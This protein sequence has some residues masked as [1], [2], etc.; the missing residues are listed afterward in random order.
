[1]RTATTA[2]G[3]SIVLDVLGLSITVICPLENRK[4]WDR[5]I[6]MESERLIFLSYIFLSSCFLV[7][8]QISNASAAG[9]TIVS[10]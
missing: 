4:T 9:P 10:A 5:K 8:N 3:R 7:V 1:M 2:N 6:E